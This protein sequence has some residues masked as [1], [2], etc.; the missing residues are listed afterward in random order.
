MLE[1]PEGRRYY[2]PPGETVSEVRRS[3]YG[4]IPH[5]EECG[6]YHFGSCQECSRCN[7][8]HHA[9]DPSCPLNE[10][11]KPKPIQYVLDRLRLVVDSSDGE[12]GG[13]D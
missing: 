11:R 6:N 3:K 2:G 10:S 5:C 4:P 13:G 7:R 1:H 9:M 8:V 12:Q